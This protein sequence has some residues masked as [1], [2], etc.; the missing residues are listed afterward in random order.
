MSESW[1]TFYTVDRPSIQWTD[2]GYIASLQLIIL[3]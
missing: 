3:F 2:R 1:Q